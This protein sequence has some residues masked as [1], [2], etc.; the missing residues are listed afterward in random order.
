MVSIRP[1]V[2]PKHASIDKNHLFFKLSTAWE[3]KPTT[4]ASGVKRE[5][6]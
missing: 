3:Q 6:S 5:S 4:T 1:A 2:S